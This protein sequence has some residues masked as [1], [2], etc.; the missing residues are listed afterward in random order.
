MNQREQRL[1]AIFITA[2]VVSFTWMGW[3]RLNEEIKRMRSEADVMRSKA[4][5]ASRTIDAF[6]AEMA[7][8]EE[9]MNTRLG[10][11]VSPQEADTRLLNAVQS[12]ASGAGLQ[13]VNT[14]F[15]PPSERG[16]LRMARYSAVVTG[17]EATIYP[18]LA[19]FHDPDKL[20]CVSGLTIKPDK[21]DET[22]VIC[23]VE[24]AQWYMPAKEEEL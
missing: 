24:F 16:D 22:I 6:A 14:K 2:L 1:L 18:W 8:A 4:D 19:T 12:S 23:D 13:L 17:Q 9:W 5:V 15:L 11:P 21:E 3:T 20:R 10:T 7:G